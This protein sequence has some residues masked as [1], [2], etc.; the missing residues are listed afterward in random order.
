MSFASVQ[1][2]IE[3]QGHSAAFAGAILA[4]ATRNA[5]AAAKKK[6]P[7]L[8]RVKGGNTSLSASHPKA[9]ALVEGRRDNMAA[10]CSFVGD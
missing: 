6:N 1:K 4:S 8:R 3:S 7:K 5:S 2:K 9:K 10:K